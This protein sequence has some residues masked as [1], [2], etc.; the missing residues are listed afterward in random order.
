VLIYF[1]NGQKQNISSAEK[2]SEKLLRLALA[3][4][5][6]RRGLS[7]AKADTESLPLVRE[8]GEKPFFEDLPQVHFSV[9]HSFHIWACAMDDSP[10]GLDLEVPGLRWKEDSPERREKIA[11][12]FFTAAENRYLEDHPDAF[13]DF[14]V[15]KEACLKLT[16]KG[17][18]GGLSSVSLVEDDRIKT[19]DQGYFF[20]GLDL[21]P[22]AAAAC[23]TEGP[24]EIEALIPLVL[25]EVAC[26]E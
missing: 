15:R 5:S 20:T 17:I 26:H 7:L 9:S 12:R 11:R 2:I 23:C 3:D 14:W 6:A 25:D 10:V 21:D 22:E 24:C 8:P 4:Y 18:S 13:F 1:F 19:V 16:G